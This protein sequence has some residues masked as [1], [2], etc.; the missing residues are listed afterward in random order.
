MRLLAKQRLAPWKK[1]LII[2]QMYAEMT[3][4]RQKRLS[5]HFC[6]SRYLA[7]LPEFRGLRVVPR[8]PYKYQTACL[9]C[10]FGFDI[11][12]FCIRTPATLQ[13][14]LY[15]GR[16]SNASGCLDFLKC[17]RFLP[18]VPPLIR[19]LGTPELQAARVCLPP[20]AQPISVVPVS[21]SRTEMHMD[22]R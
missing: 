14:R 22:T 7:T 2:W 5:K 15:I 19:L 20:C 4:G 11:Y 17:F 1:I 12:G 16:R 10:L 18:A 21:Q 3:A 13:R 6:T 8:P 9:I